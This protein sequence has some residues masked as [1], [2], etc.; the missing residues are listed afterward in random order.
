MCR[1]QG[2]YLLVVGQNTG[3]YIESAGKLMLILKDEDAD[4]KTEYIYF[5]YIR[6][7]CPNAPLTIKI[8][9]SNKHLYAVDITRH[10]LSDYP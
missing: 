10:Y 8:G 9:L 2:T 5:I 3:I 7:V 6:L 4:T 1:I